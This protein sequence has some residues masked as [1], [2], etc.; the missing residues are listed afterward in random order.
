MKK[1]ITEFKAFAVKGNM[2]DM[3]IG[4]VIGAA[5]SG[6]VNSL[7]KDIINP[8]FGLVIGSDE[9]KN[10]HYTLQSQLL[11]S[12]G[13]V[14]ASEVVLK[15]GSFLSTLLNFLIISFTLFGLMKMVVY[16]KQKAE[17]IT[18]TSVKTPKDIELLNDIKELLKKEK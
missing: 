10:L 14:I 7:V 16:L 15:Y 2:L 18:D 5:F 6:I 3:A 17:D 1:I 8:I 12:N 11:D 13:N 9:L 4:I